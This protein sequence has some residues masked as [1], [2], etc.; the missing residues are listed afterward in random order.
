MCRLFASLAADTSHTVPYSRDIADQRRK[1]GESVLRRCEEH[2]TAQKQYEAESQA[3]VQAARQR[4][5]EEKER[6]EA[7]EV[8]RPALLDLTQC[9]TDG[10]SFPLRSA[11][12]SRSCGSRPRSSRRNVG[13][14]GSR[15]S[16]GRG[17]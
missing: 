12:A 13:L 4:R 3:K 5:Q 2:L 10:D 17:R 8:C 1:Y 15:R 6:Q 16:S 9:R 7:A 14:R 11:N